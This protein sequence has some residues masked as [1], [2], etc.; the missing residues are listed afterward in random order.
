MH[1]GRQAATKH[2][3][4]V[5]FAREAHRKVGSGIVDFTVQASSFFTANLDFILVPCSLRK[6][7]HRIKCQVNMGNRTPA[8]RRELRRRIVT[9]HNDQQSLNSGAGGRPS[10][11]R[12]ILCVMQPPA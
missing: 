4:L 5:V 3:A 12:R 9:G 8:P 7:Y 6:N 10:M 1:R 11:I 2:E